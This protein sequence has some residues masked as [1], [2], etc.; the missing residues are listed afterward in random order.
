MAGQPRLDSSLRLLDSGSC[1]VIADLAHASTL[2][3]DRQMWE[4]RRERPLPQ[5]NLPIFPDL[6][7]KTRFQDPINGGEW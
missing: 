5:T 1:T 7:D 3:C 4:P 6:I 2:G